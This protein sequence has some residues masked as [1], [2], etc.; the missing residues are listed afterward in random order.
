LRIY[1][2]IITLIFNLHS[3][4]NAEEQNAAQVE[5]LNKIAEFVHPN[6]AEVWKTFFSNFEA[7][8]L[9]EWNFSEK[10]GSFC[11]TLKTPLK[12]WVPASKATSEPR[13][14]SIL[15]FGVGNRVEGRLNPQKQSIEFNRG[16]QIYCKY[17]IGFIT[18]PITVDVYSLAYKNNDLITLEAGRAGFS[19]KRSKPFEKYISSWTHPENVVLGDYTTYLDLKSK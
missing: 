8:K 10:T 18:V 11:M 12:F 5:A 3:F 15:I 14:G 9:S 7:D 19:E 4:A 16:F 13:P 17:K 6:M 2:L 1:F